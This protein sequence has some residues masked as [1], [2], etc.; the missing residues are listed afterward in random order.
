MD[1][2][3]DKYSVFD[4]FNLIIGGFAFLLGLALCNY[5]QAVALRSSLISEFGD[6]E[7]IAIIISVLFI[8]CSLIAGTVIN[9]IMHFFFYTILKL[10]DKVFKNCLNKSGLI[11]NEY[12][13]RDYREKAK[14]YLELTSI[15]DDDDFT[16]AQCSAF[17]GHCIYYI[18]VRDKDRKTEKL[19][20]VKGLSELFAFVFFL[21]PTISFFIYIF[22]NKLCSVN[23]TTMFFY[24]LFLIFGCIFFM[25][26]QRALENRIKMVLAVYNA[27][28]DS[29]YG[30]G[31]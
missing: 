5:T 23:G 25:R 17:F 26:A 30:L 3:T 20:E 28:V 13:L 12:K 9:E 10:E 24:T 15:N 21:I 1:S 16:P 29:R 11:K 22:T 4:F 14:E 6:I 18:H 31:N 27:C 2:V 19:R 8:G 7:S